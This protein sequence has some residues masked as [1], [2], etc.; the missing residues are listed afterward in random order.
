MIAAALITQMETSKYIFKVFLMH[1]KKFLPK[2]PSPLL[3][4]F[5]PSLHLKPMSMLKD[6]QLLLNISKPQTAST[7][8]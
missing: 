4:Q 8:Q 7:S 5:Q 2:S 6:R 1:Q 3:K